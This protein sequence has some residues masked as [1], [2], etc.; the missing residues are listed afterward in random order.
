MAVR[1]RSNVRY[2]GLETAKR[3][4]PSAKQ[5]SEKIGDLA[6]CYQIIKSNSTGFRRRGKAAGYGATSKPSSRFFTKGEKAVASLSDKRAVGSVEQGDRSRT[7]SGKLKNRHAD[8]GKKLSRR[9]VEELRRSKEK[10]ETAP[11]KNTE[12]IGDLQAAL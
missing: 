9:V 5:R 11:T 12:I 4:G 8:N 1:L 7:Q 6:G 3:E 10:R 2:H